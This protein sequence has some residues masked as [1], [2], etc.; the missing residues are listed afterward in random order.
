MFLISRLLHSRSLSN[1]GTLDN[2]ALATVL[3]VI[4]PSLSIKLQLLGRR[5]TRCSGETLACMSYRSSVTGRHRGPKRKLGDRVHVVNVTVFI[6]ECGTAHL[7]VYL[8]FGHHP[9]H[10]AYICARFCFFRGL[11]C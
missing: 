6:V 2:A 8:T 3:T 7:C 4:S 5:K 1:Q 11:H 10:L 9:H